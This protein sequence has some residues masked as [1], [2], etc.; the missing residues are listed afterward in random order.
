MPK[1]LLKIE[2]RLSQDLLLPIAFLTSYLFFLS[3]RPVSRSNVHYLQKRIDFLKSLLPLFQNPHGVPEP[4]VSRLNALTPMNFSALAPLLH[5]QLTTFFDEERSLPE[6][7]I[8]TDEKPGPEFF[9]ASKRVLLIMGPGIGIGDEIM[10]YRLPSWMKRAFPGLVID[11]M[12]AYRGLWENVTAV[13]EKFCYTDYLTLLNAL[14]G[15]APFSG[16]GLVILADFEKPGLSGAVCRDRAIKRYMEISTGMRSVELADMGKRIAFQ[17]QPTGRYFS[18][19]YH[20]LSAL[21]SWM[22][23]AG[24][25]NENFPDVL[26]QRDEKPV[27]FPR[28][29]ISPFTSKYE[30]S[31]AYW[32]RLLAALF[33]QTGS[34]LKIRL[35]SG[36]NPATERFSA[37][38]LHSLNRSVSPAVAV[39]IAYSNGKRTLDL[40]DAFSEMDKAAVVICSDSYAAHAAPLYGC[41]TLVIAASN[42]SGW[43]VPNMGS[44][45]F[46]AESEAGQ[47]A[48]AMRMVLAKTGIF[49]DAAG[50]LPDDLEVEHQFRQALRNLRQSVNSADPV[51]SF[52]LLQLYNQFCEAC[53]AM[54][55]DIRGWAPLFHGLLQD[56]S[57]E[58]GAAKISPEL[59]RKENVS[60]GLMNHLR[61]MLNQWQNTNLYKF[62]G[63]AFENENQK[64]EHT[65]IQ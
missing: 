47:V 38:L 15:E 32:S 43:R 29:F 34:P 2:S 10:F 65:A 36:P 9:S 28:I 52:I 33:D 11:A 56:F 8:V 35:D 13:D 14:R 44:F 17:H 30:P 1:N 4:I 26:S 61:D 54:S 41:T 25:A 40:Q 51:D 60:E 58:R 37:Q 5:S 23:I 59:F 55:K 16:Y 57:Y 18:N 62:L 63:L 22:G 6:D 49:K 48:E 42:L 7:F 12:S 19:Y 64:A 3:R 45:Y 50:T 53:S 46:P 39:E 21:L 31:V 24:S 20:G 27:E